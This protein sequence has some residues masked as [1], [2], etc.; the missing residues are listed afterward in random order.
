MHAAASQLPFPQ[1]LS[2]AGALGSNTAALLEL[3][4]VANRL[5]TTALLDSGATHN[6]I[7]RGF[8]KECGAVL[9]WAMPMCVSLATKSHVVSA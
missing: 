7:S 5:Q 9:V 8:A 3:P 1:C 6:F 2:Q 4:V